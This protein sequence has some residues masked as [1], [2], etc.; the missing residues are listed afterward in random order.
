LY[1]FWPSSLFGLSPLRYSA[2]HFPLAAD[3]LFG[4]PVFL[5]STRECT[6]QMSCRETPPIIVGELFN[7]TPA[8]GWSTL[9]VNVL[10]ALWSGSPRLMHC[11][12]HV[13]C[14]FPPRLRGNSNSA[15]VSPS[16]DCRSV[17]DAYFLIWWIPGDRGFPVSRAANA[18]FF[19]LIF[20]VGDRSRKPADFAESSPL[21]VVGWVFF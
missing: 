3:A 19:V 7:C 1:Q 13:A 10:G 12:G 15:L 2:S 8:V 4:I 17:Y 20:K 11:S 18:V 16:N 14:P 5:F 9:K 6:F 21:R